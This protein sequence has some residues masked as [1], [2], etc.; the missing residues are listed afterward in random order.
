MR[1]AHIRHLSQQMDGR[2]AIG[3]EPH[4]WEE[5]DRFS[6]IL[7]SYVWNTSAFYRNT[8]GTLL[9]TS[10]WQVTGSDFVTFSADS[11]CFTPFD[12]ASDE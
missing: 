7:A 12:I 4:V 3:T 1:S 5:I 6:Q 2:A 10:A 11:P 8:A 9:T